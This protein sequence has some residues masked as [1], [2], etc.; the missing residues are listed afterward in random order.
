M[1]G[2][3][4]P[5][6]RL[7]P[8]TSSRQCVLSSQNSSL[9][10][11][12]SLPQLPHRSWPCHRLTVIHHQRQKKPS[13]RITHRKSEC[14]S[15]SITPS[16]I[17]ATAAPAPSFL[18]PNRKR[19]AHNSEAYSKLVAEAFTMLANGDSLGINA[20]SDVK[21]KQVKEDSVTLVTSSKPVLLLSSLVRSPSV[22]P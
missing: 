6:R 15:I 11:L 17:T 7:A 21:R 5:R 18:P 4:N 22:C 12:N 3:A 1:T 9:A 14:Y 8:R 19:L 2:V 10:A 16:K 13:P 20:K